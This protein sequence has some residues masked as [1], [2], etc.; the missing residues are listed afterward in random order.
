MT[1]ILVS[2]KSVQELKRNWIEKMTRLKFGERACQA[3]DTD[4]DGC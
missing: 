3:L 4:S 1:R 2:H